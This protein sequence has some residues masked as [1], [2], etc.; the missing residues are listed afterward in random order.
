MGVQVV[1]SETCVQTREGANDHRAKA[2]IEVS[3]DTIETSDDTD[4]PRRIE[5]RQWC[6]N[7]ISVLPRPSV[8]QLRVC[9]AVSEEIETHGRRK[10][11]EPEHH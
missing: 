8:S 7:S 6:S 1:L 2:T 10:E 5:N 11:L 4:Q 9:A 3:A